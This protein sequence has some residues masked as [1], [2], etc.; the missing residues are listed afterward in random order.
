MAENIIPEMIP[1]NQW[2]MGSVFQ[3]SEAE[4]I[5]RNIVMLQKKVNP[6]AWTP[7][8]WEDY[9]N[10]CTHNV[11][12]QEQRVLDAFVGGG[13]PVINTSTKLSCGWLDYNGTHYSFTEKMITM[14]HTDFGVVEEYE[15]D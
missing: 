10:F 13:K 15:E 4:T 3:N 1:T 14:L 11:W 7:F 5:L 2:F 6:K 8:S 9:K 12:D